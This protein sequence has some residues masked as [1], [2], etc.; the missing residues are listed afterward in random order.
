TDLIEGRHRIGFELP[1]HKTRYRTVEVV[2]GEPLRVPAVRLDLVDGRLVVT[3]D[4][5]GATVTVDDVY[6]GET[7]LDF[8]V[9]PDDDLDVGV[10]KVG[11]DAES[12]TVGVAPGKTRTV[13]FMLKPILGEVAIR[14]APASAVLFVDGKSLGNANQ[15]LRLVAIPHEIIVQAEGYEPHRVTVLPRPGVGQSLDIRLKTPE[16][17]EAE[18]RPRVIQ[19]AHGQELVLVDGGRFTMGASRREPGRR[20]NETVREVELTRP[21]YL[22]TREISNGEFREF[23]KE[24]LSGAVEEFNLE[25]DRHPV[26]RVTWDEAA[27]FCNWLSAQDSLPAA[28]ERRSGRMVAVRPLNT[29]YRLP[30]EAEWAFAA[31]YAGGETPLKY[32]WGDEL[33]VT[34]DS[35]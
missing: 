17:I 32:P 1:G 21:F 27:L 11:Y 12:R 35:G 20:A 29:G 10:V 26:V 25:N 18:S 24:H 34:A 5:P 3:S 9:S 4:P 30:T 7:P 2:A 15:T 6:H 33:P 23:R 28:Y 13:E 8:Y 14:A 19:T 22:A 31:R 16:Q